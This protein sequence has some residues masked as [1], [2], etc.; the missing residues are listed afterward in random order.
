M[1]RFWITFLSIFSEFWPPTWRPFFILLAGAG[2]AP[3]AGHPSHLK[4]TTQSA[5]MTANIVFFLDFGS[6]FFQKYVF[7]VVIFVVV[8]CF[9][10]YLY[11][12]MYVKSFAQ[13]CRV[14]AL[15]I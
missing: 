13:S 5:K 11:E 4:L 6:F 7:F 14:V 1:L 15:S 8:F 10:V 2:S 12:C 3:S 9:F